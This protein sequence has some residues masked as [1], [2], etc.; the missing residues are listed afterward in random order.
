MKKLLA[1]LL[2]LITCFS[3]GCEKDDA[4]TP[5]PSPTPIGSTPL[6]YKVTDTDGDFIWLFG[7][8][9][10]GRVDYYP[11]PDYVMNALENSDALAVEADIISFEKD[12]SAQTEALSQLLYSDG[13]TIEEHI[14]EQL[15]LDAVEILDEIGYTTLYDY[16]CPSLWTNL[17]DNILYEKLKIDGELGVDRHLLKYAKKNDIKIYEIESAEFQYGMLANFSPELQEI[18]LKESVQNFAKPEKAKKEL[19]ELIDLWYKGDE[20]AL[21]EA[22]KPDFTDVTEEEIALADEYVTKMLTDRN[23]GMTDFAVD[24]LEKGEEI[25]ICVGTAHVIGEDSITDLLKE[26]GYKVE[27]VK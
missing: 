17:I 26:K 14:D 22:V 25:F 16:Y 21:I 19:N 18:L 7:S 4:P 12:V 8:I 13:T 6:L 11:L 23:M 24:A 15:Y 5:S 2:T 10:V 3:L 9:H 1:L 20:K 27:I